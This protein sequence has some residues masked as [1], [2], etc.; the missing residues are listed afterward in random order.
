MQPKKI[1]PYDLG[2]MLD[3]VP[4]AELIKRAGT[5]DSCNIFT[6]LGQD[7]IVTTSVPAT[8]EGEKWMREVR[9]SPGGGSPNA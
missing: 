3:A 7:Y 2:K 6:F 4:S 5:I 8:P 9:A 1:H